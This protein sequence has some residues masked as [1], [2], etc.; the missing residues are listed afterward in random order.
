MA[1][2]SQILAKSAALLNDQDRATYTDEVLLA[3]LNIALSELQETFELNNIPATQKTS[4]VIN[5]PAG[6]TKIAFSGTLAELPPDLIEIQQLFE[7]MEGQN[8]WV[9]M[10]RRDYLTRD[11]V[12]SNFP[13]QMFGVWAWYDQAIHVL[14]STQDNDIKI[15]YIGGLFTELTLPGLGRKNPILN[16]DTILE[17]RVAGL[18]AEFI[19]EN[20]RRADSLN[21]TAAAAMQRSLGISVKAK[22]AIA[23]R[24]RPFR[25]SWKNRRWLA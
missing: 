16:T 14:E 17:F 1:A 10:T 22:Q 13:V 2:W 23:V 24:R 8:T 5:V 25:A 7:S 3:Y 19:E 9:P 15:D 4:S 6:E 21:G 20:A 11:S 12:G 18:A